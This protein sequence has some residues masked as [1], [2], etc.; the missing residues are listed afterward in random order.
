MNIDFNNQ[1]DMN[2]EVQYGVFIYNHV[3]L[4]FIDNGQ[5]FWTWK[6]QQM[7]IA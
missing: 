4:T 3:L 7:G 1:N 6:T 2:N 5:N